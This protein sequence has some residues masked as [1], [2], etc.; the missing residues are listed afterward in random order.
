MAPELLSGEE[1]MENNTT[2][3]VYAFG[4]VLYEVQKSNWLSRFKVIL[5]EMIFQIFSGNIPFHEIANNSSV[6]YRILL[7][8]RPPRPSHSVPSG[9]S[10]NSLGLD[11]CMWSIMEDCWL[12]EPTMRPTMSGIVTRLPERVVAISKTDNTAL[13]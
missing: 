2:S 6:T 9:I 1:G 3:D 4:Y 5:T 7:G 10:C 12:H 13:P 11:D 8:Q